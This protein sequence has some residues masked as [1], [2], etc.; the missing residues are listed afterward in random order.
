DGRLSGRDCG[1][2]EVASDHEADERP[3]GAD[4]RDQQE[5]AP[6]HEARPYEVRQRRSSMERAGPEQ[7]EEQTGAAGGG[8]DRQLERSGP[9]LT[10]EDECD[11]RSR[12]PGE[13]GEQQGRGDVDAKGASRLWAET[14]S[15]HL[16]SW[17]LARASPGTKP[18]ADP[19]TIV[20]QLIL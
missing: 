17:G 14:G 7:R 15:D 8:H 20:S 1:A 12:Q 3:H 16:G 18:A 9:Q 2:E 13:D 5:D 19:R 4:E 6:G 11:E 10:A